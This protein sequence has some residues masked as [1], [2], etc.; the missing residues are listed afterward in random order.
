[1]DGSLSWRRFQSLIL[2]LPPDSA[3]VCVTNPDQWDREEHLLAG[4]YDLL[5]TA[6]W[7]RGG[8]KSAPRPK[9]LPRPGVKPPGVVRKY[10]TESMPIDE[11]QARL[12]RKNHRGG[13]RGSRA[14]AGVHQ[15][16]SVS[17]GD[18]SEHLA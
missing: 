17:E 15:S 7:Q 8:K 18:Q 2:H 12:N 16:G 11:M 9:P 3:S 5:A 13:V 6:N 10:G 14:R 4:I 1:V